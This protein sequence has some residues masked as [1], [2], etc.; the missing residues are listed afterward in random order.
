MA[1]SH[2]ADQVTGLADDGAVLCAGNSIE[3]VVPRIQAILQHCENWG[4]ESGLKFSPS[5]TKIVIFGDT[6]LPDPVVHL[7]GE[8][9][10]VVPEITYLGIILDNRLS[11]SSHALD[12]AQRAQKHLMSLQNLMGS[13]FGPSPRVTAWLYTAVVRPAL[14]YGGHIWYHRLSC[15]NANMINKLNRLALTSIAPVL[16]G[17]PTAGLE[18]IYNISPLPL[19]FDRMTHNCILRINQI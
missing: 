15:R 3:E 16:P 14:A 19:H 13:V 8:V 4:R 17:T 10:E 11:F 1:L 2:I 7:Y 6:L 5:K 12:K 9:V 18:V